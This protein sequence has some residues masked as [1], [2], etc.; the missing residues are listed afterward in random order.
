[1]SDVHVWRMLHTTTW[2][3]DPDRL[4]ELLVGLCDQP[5]SVRAPLFGALER[6][7][8]HSDHRLRE[9]AV[10]LLAGAHG[11]PAWTAVVRMLADRSAPVRDAALELLHIN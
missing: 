6:C 11:W 3:R 9:A 1:M 4:H 10:R 8:D 5:F 2:D 7:L